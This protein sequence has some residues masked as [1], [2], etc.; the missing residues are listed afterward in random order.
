MGAYPGF[1]RAKAGTPA[2]GT[3][4][5]ISDTRLAV[6]AM[7]TNCLNPRNIEAD[8]VSVGGSATYPA[9][10]PSTPY[11][12][13]ADPSTAPTVRYGGKQ[14]VQHTTQPAL[15]EFPAHAYWYEL[16]P[17]PYFRT[18]WGDTGKTSSGANST[19]AKDILNALV[20]AGYPLRL[21]Q[22]VYLPGAYKTGETNNLPAAAWLD[23]NNGWLYADGETL[24]TTTKTCDVTNGSNVVACTNTSG[25]SVGMHVW[26]TGIA[27]SSSVFISSINPNVSFNLQ[28]DKSGA[29]PVNFNATAG[30]TGTTLNF[31]NQVPELRNYTTSR[32][33][34]PA[35]VARVVDSNGDN[36]G[37]WFAKQLKTDSNYTGWPI[38]GLAM[39][40][41]IPQEGYSIAAGDLINAT[42]EGTF[43][44]YGS[45]HHRVGTRERCTV[46][47]AKD[48][49]NAGWIVIWNG[50]R[51]Y[52]WRLWANGGT[53]RPASW[54]GQHD[55]VLM[56]GWGGFYSDESGGSQ[57]G[58]RQG[59]KTAAQLR[60][61]STRK[62]LGNVWN[63]KSYDDDNFS[64]AGRP[65]SQPFHKNIRFALASTLLS[66]SLFAYSQISTETAG[67][68]DLS[69]PTECMFRFYV[70]EMDAPI[71]VPVEPPPAHDNAAMLA[72][73]IWTREYQN[74]LVIVRPK[75]TNAATWATEPPINY[76]LPFDCRR[77]TGT[78]DP[79]DDGSLLPAGSTV[80]LEPRSALILLKA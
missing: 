78:L 41:V 68:F 34:S 67:G 79:A 37:Q 69:W 58:W 73:G 7:S 46:T 60:S 51:Q 14:W 12:M 64:G 75:G 66:D 18:I 72:A 45:G 17:L 20:A 50:L 19:A 52:G 30:A 28:T 16:R 47:T 21:W 59:L 31:S 38:Y 40:N 80:S 9:W 29:A 15:T 5:K 13:P 70:A 27:E 36:W 4:Q 74:G 65:R 39:D 35:R 33:V 71:G 63:W 11:T 57:T 1:L 6:L 61:E 53:K 62:S 55:G 49:I 23:A 77:L 24:T 2:E 3:F 8:H 26:G 42:W 76:T 25:L 54:A 32:Q 22:Y 44:Q 10:A 56:E 48:A 43:N